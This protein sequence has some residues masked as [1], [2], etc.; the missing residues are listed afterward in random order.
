MQKYK[1]LDN[2]AGVGFDLTLL[3]MLIQEKLL[4]GLSRVSISL[5]KYFMAYLRNSISRLMNFYEILLKVDFLH[6]KMSYQKKTF[7]GLLRVSKYFN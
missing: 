2:S 5:Q 7:A 6:L 3:I 1:T 4:A